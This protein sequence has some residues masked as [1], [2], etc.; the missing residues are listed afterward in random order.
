MIHRLASVALISALACTMTQP[1]TQ[2]AQPT[3]PPAVGAEAAPDGSAVDAGTA[4][5]DAGTAAVDA[6]PDPSLTALGPQ[7]TA[8]GVRFNVRLDTP[9]TAS[10]VTGSFNA[11]NP[12]DPAFRLEDPDGDGVFA[13]TA[14]LAAGRYQYKLVVDGRWTLD[15]AAPGTAPDGFGG[16][17][18]VFVVP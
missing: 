2:Q 10:F 4:A 14:A 5:V 7:V 9:A 12:S 11:W 3:P 6:G 15:P 8:Q 1:L 16:Q 13:V 17:N 18:G